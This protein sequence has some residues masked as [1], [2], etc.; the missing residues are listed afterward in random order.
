MKTVYSYSRNQITQIF[1]AKDVQLLKNISRQNTYDV[2]VYTRWCL[3]AYI[4]ANICHSVA[5]FMGTFGLYVINLHQV[6][7]EW[8]SKEAWNGQDM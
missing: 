5:V 6:S 3:H 8:S 7:F 4:M 1:L 2:Y